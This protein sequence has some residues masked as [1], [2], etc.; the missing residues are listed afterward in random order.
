MG[1]LV[2]LLHGDVVEG[3]DGGA[4]GGRDEHPEVAGVGGAAGHALVGGH[5]AARLDGGE[6]PSELRLDVRGHPVRQ[7]VARRT[8]WLSASVSGLSGEEDAGGR[9]EQ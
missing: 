1:L 3:G 2:H 6:V 4:V 7:V 8:G 9:Q 5:A